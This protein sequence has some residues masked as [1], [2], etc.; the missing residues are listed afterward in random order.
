MTIVP[1]LYLAISPAVLWPYVLGA[2]LFLL[3]LLAI[4]NDFSE[5][6]GSDKALVLGRLC[7]AVPLAAFAG[8][9]LASAKFVMMMVPS[10]MPWRLFW[11][12]FVGFALIAAALSIVTKIKIRLSGTLLG[13]MIFL[14]VAM[15]HIPRVAANPH[16]RF[17]WVV[18]VRDS[19][20]ALGAWVFATTVREKSRATSGAV[21]KLACLFM[22]STLIFYGVEHFLHP[23]CLPVVPL[24]KQTP[25]W[26]PARF[27]IDYLT[28]VIL[29]VSGASI[30]ARRKAYS[31]ATFLGV[32]ILV[33]V[34]FVY[35][36]VFIASASDP[37]VGK[38]I[39]GLNYF[40]DTL[41]F[42]GTILAL[43]NGLRAETIP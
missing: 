2:V 39:E 8:E 12:Y 18:A 25:A 15:L 41:M 22:G 34:A 27:V 29:L 40:M 14:F 36:P 28:G 3:G 20:F 30:L 16:D 5:A 32:T 21:V 31:A 42:G 10:Y 1:A 33:L 23:E 7:Y 19:C 9:H 35:L 13:I 6:L 11:A 43:A 17:A 26:I 38:K 4:R 37:D 24:E